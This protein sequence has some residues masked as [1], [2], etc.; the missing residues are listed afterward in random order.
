ME[1]TLL[2]L[3]EN[4]AENAAVEA[5]ARSAALSPSRMMALS[6]ESF[7]VALRHLRRWLRAQ[8]VVARYASGGS[9]TDAAL[10]VGFN[11]SAHLSATFRDLF[12]VA[13]SQVLRRASRPH[14]AVVSE[15]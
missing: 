1:R 9:L 5:S 3:E 13:P 2:W 12:G 4:L 8:A 15:G 10:D 6:R 7:G 11:S 14:I